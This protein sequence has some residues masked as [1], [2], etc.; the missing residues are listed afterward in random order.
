MEPEDGG[1]EES[2]ER[3][4]D[5][6]NDEGNILED[7]GNRQRR[8]VIRGIPPDGAAEM[9]PVGAAYVPLPVPS[10]VN[11]LDDYDVDDVPFKYG[12][13]E[14]QGGIEKVIPPV[15]IPPGVLTDY[16]KKD[17]KK[18]PEDIYE[19]VDELQETSRSMHA[20][21]MPNEL[22]RKQLIELMSKYHTSFA[23]RIDVLKRLLSQTI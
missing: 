12:Y 10:K 4:G 21:P 22:V 23:V 5:E 7:S 1:V 2:K 14:Y 19:A 15:G 20:K 6:G 16:E 13:L 8:R 18:S 17:M 9:A 3:D 11:V